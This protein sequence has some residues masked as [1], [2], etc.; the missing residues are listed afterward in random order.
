MSQSYNNIGLFT[1]I[2]MLSPTA[3]PPSFC[4]AGFVIFECAL[5]SCIILRFIAPI[6]SLAPPRLHV[7]SLHCYL[8]VV[9]ASRFALPVFVRSSRLLCRR[10]LSS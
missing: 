6:S 4:W 5:C 8:T 7:F 2:G 9:P 1:N 3:A 10:S